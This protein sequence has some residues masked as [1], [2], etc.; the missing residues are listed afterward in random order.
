MESTCHA[1]RI[2]NRAYIAHCYQ[3]EPKDAFHTNRQSG[4]FSRPCDTCHTGTVPNSRM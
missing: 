1:I 4:V 3:N 2:V